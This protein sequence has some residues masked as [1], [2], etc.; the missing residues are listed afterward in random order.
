MSWQ[1]V[2]A[3]ALPS[4]STHD[5]AHGLQVLSKVSPYNPYGHV[6]SQKSSLGVGYLNLPEGH[7]KHSCAF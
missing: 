6:V 4:Q 2:H 7:V 1:L 3:L 5:G